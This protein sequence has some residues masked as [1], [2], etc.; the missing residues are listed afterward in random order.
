MRGK[1]KPGLATAPSRVLISR[2]SSRGRLREEREE[3]GQ[4]RLIYRA[5]SELMRNTSDL[6]RQDSWRRLPDYSRGQRGT[7]RSNSSSNIVRERIPQRGVARENSRPN[8]GRENS[9]P[10]LG[11]EKLL[12]GNSDYKL[13]RESSAG[14]LERGR[15]QTGL[16]RSSSSHS[17]V[18]GNSFQLPRQ[19]SSAQLKSLSRA[20]SKGRIVTEVCRR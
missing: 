7:E 17:L 2:T 10:N 5:G 18:R 13:I 14:Q 3:F 20:L 11:R 8:L 9:R 1:S 6:Q 4:A 16:L 15:S 19:A 12:R